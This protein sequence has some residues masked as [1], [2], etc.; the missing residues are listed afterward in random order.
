MEGAGVLVADGG[1][2]GL[3]G[4]VA[5]FHRGE[6]GLGEHDSPLDELRVVGLG[7]GFL[8]GLHVVV[9]RGSGSEFNRSTPGLREED[10]AADHFGVI[11][12]GAGAFELADVVVGARAGA[13]FHAGGVALCGLHEDGFAD[14]LGAVGLWVGGFRGGGIGGGG[15]S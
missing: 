1:H 8:E 6:A 11:L 12:G 4:G 13:E 9:S 3:L 7:A 14:G 10:A 5:E 15:V 2:S